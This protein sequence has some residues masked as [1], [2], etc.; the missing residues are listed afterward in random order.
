[1]DSKH[2]YKL[3][4]VHIPVTFRGSTKTLLVSERIRTDDAVPNQNIVSKFHQS[5]GM[6]AKVRI[7]LVALR[8]RSSFVLNKIYRN[9]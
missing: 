4:T 6:V 9:V 1:M 7:R 2:V 5:S 3:F 8:Y